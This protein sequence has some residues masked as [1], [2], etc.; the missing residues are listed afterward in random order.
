MCHHDLLTM[1]SL[2][3]VCLLALLLALPTAATAEDTSTKTPPGA[4]AT[5]PLDRMLELVKASEPTDDP[6]PPPVGA[7]LDRFALEGRIVD[8]VIEGVAQVQVTVLSKGWVEVPVLDLG[9]GIS[10][11]QL[12]TLEGSSLTVRDGTLTLL[13]R[14]AQVQSFELGLRVAG[15]DG[16]GE[17]GQARLATRGATIT[18]A[19]ITHDA[20]LYRLDGPGLRRQSDAT[21]VPGVAGALDLRWT[22]VAP[23]PEVAVVE[24]AAAPAIEP[25]VTRGDATLVLT[26]DGRRI[27][28]YRYTVQLGRATPITITLPAEQTVTRLFVNGQGRPFEVADGTLTVPVAPAREGETTATFEL[29]T[30]QD[31]KPLSLAGRLRFATPTLDRSVDAL[32]VTLFLPPVFTY[33]WVGGALSP[34]T[35]HSLPTFDWSM[36]APGKPQSFGRDLVSGP[37]DLELGYTVDLAGQYYE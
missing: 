4:S 18:T 32:A 22:R 31:G 16:G 26:L 5:M 10:I 25:T 2:S 7:T 13:T 20:G 33:Q 19:R 35:D 8:D 17:S 9:A 14:Q 34:R 21:V 30:Q 27:S 15:A 11:T 29:V 12:P 24:E 1:P 3:P 6:G 37:S 23:A 28:R 36:P